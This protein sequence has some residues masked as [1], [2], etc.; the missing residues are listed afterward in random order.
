M[1]V[2]GIHIPNHLTRMPNRELFASEMLQYA[3][4]HMNDR[5][6]II[7]DYNMSMLADSEGPVLSCTEK[8]VELHGLGWIDTWRFTH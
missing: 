4:N 2:L 6:V 5:C 3:K 8:L 7:G 1:H